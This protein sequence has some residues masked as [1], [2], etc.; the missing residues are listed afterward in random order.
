MDFRDGG[1][2]GDDTGG[3]TDTAAVAHDWSV[4]G[5]A[6]SQ[7]VGDGG[8]LVLD[9]DDGGSGLGMHGLVIGAPAAEGGSGA[10]AVHLAPESERAVP[11]SA[12]YAL[13]RGAEGEGLGSAVVLLQDPVLGPSLAIGATNAEGSSGTESGAV[14]IVS[15]A[16]VE[17][18]I[19]LPALESSRVR[20]SRW[21][22]DFGASLATADVDGDGRSDLIVGA[23]KESFEAGRVYL[24]TADEVAASADSGDATGQAGDMAAFD[25]LGTSVAAGGDVDGDGIDDVVVGAPGF[26]AD[27]NRSGE[28]GCAVLSGAAWAAAGEV[29]T[30]DFAMAF[31]VGDGEDDRLG[32]GAHSLALADTDGDDRADLLVGVPSADRSVTDGGG[33]ALFSGGSLAGT[34]AISEAGLVLGGTGEAGSSVGALFGANGGSLLFIG[35][36]LAD[37]Q[38]RRLRL[39][40]ADALVSDADVGHDD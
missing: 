12:G 14:A 22:G 7:R 28:G 21:H 5:E 25:F 3:A 9:L 35:A 15:Q 19:P 8:L 31:V 17:G 29:S 4:V 34:L 13:I 38:G 18:P 39:Y 37:G 26:D 2:K 33:A 16:V 10:V 32:D 20:G 27:G 36:P 6:A 23:P 24:F 11:F 1:Q 30:R 40:V